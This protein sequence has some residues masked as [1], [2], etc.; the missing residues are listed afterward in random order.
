MSDDTVPICIANLFDF[1]SCCMLPRVLIKSLRW[2][3]GRCPF[4]KCLVTFKYIIFSISTT[5]SL[6][7][8][9]YRVLKNLGDIAFVIKTC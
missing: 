7:H 1:G 6:L 8:K 4:N 2:F 3:K 5:D 9:K